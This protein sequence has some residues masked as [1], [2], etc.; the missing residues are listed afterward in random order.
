MSPAARD[1]ATKLGYTN[2]KVFHDGLPVWQ[3]THP[4]ALSPRLLKEAWL[5]KQQPIVVLDARR[6]P[7]GGV[8]PG[9]VAFADTSK[10]SLDRLYKFRKVKPPI[11]VYD[12]DGGKEAAKVAGA[13]VK[14]GYVAMILTGG[15]KAWKAAGYEL[16]KGAAAKEIVYVP[17][18]KPGEIPVPEFKA[19]A[20]AI[21]ADTVVLDV[22][23]AD[24]V[25]AGAIPGSVNIPADQV[26]ARAAE[27]PKDKRIVTHCSTGLRAEMVYNV[28]KGAGFTR[29][30]FVNAA[31]EFDGGKLDLGN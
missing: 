4:N 7:A 22:R 10:K 21:P 31:V 6:R 23:N 12:A 25:A 5:D 28:L 14:E 15:A 13:I 9:A 27:L 29:V 19:I 1:A 30:A 8:I 3:K 18:P 11:V 20:A 16:A 24:E 17:K 26:A 2:V